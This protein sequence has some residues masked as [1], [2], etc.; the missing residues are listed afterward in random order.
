V[1]NFAKYFVISSIVFDLRVKYNKTALRYIYNNLNIEDCIAILI[2]KQK[3]EKFFIKT[4]L[5]DL[6]IFSLSFA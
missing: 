4:I 6:F 3:F 5:K 1:L 2:R